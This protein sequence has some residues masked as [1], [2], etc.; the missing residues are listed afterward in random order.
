MRDRDT[1]I[2]FPHAAT[3]SRKRGK[4]HVEVHDPRV[5]VAMIEGG[6]KLTL[7][8]PE[9]SGM[10]GDAEPVE[11]RIEP[12]DDSQPF[13]AWRLMPKLPLYVSYARAALAWRWDDAGRALQA[14]R[15]VGTTR[16]GL[17]D[18]FYRAVGELHAALV[19]QGEPHP[20]KALAEMQPVDISTASRWISEARRRGYL[21]EK[22]EA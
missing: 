2:R 11:I 21:R 5:S 1:V 15:E 8:F 14:L 6:V 12:H 7:F 10:S 4:K 18:D 13:D 16:R 9:E 20:V 19:D 22:A 17:N 3:V